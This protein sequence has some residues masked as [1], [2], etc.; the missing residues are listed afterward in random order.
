MLKPLGT[1]GVTLTVLLGACN[2]DQVVSDA[3]EQSTVALAQLWGVRPNKTA[4][5]E[6]RDIEAAVLIEAPETGVDLGWGWNT[7]RA[8]PIPTVCVEFARDSFDSQTTT[9]SFNEVNDSFELLET[10]DVSAEVS[11]KSIGYEAKGKADF[12]KQ[13]NISGF[14]STFV[15]EAEVQNGASFAAPTPPRELRLAAVGLQGEGAIRLTPEAVALARQGTERFKEVCGNGFVSATMGGARLTAVVNIQTSSRQERETVQAAVSGSGWGVKVEAAMKNDKSTAVGKLEREISF[16]QAGGREQEL[17]TDADKI[18]ARVQELAKQA[19]TAEKLFQIAVTPYEILENWP[20]GEELTGEE[21]E[22]NE[23]AS[24]WG[25]YNTLYDEIQAAM[26]TPGDFVVPVATCVSGEA[27]CTV[28]FK[29][30]ADATVLL[31]DLQD[32]VLAALDRLELDA[33]S[34]VVSEEDCAFNGETYRSP[35]AV[36]TR[37]P[38]PACFLVAGAGACKPAEA[39]PDAGSLAR[40][41][42]ANLRDMAKSR[43]RFGSLTPGCLS[44]ADIRAWSDRAGLQSMA[45][46]NTDVLNA[47]VAELNGREVPVLA[48]DPGA[49]AAATIWYGGDHAQTVATV[50]AQVRQAQATEAENKG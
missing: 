35:Y 8:E 44:N 2:P 40:F 27:G 11:V 29:K 7:F 45:L 32:E 41:V 25:A 28:S 43:C 49:Q 33:E 47:T 5:S 34:C 9:L 1:V 24:L 18:I 17:P 13:V 31:E 46:E 48:G 21:A 3:D 23:L 39:S 4:R 37:L 16:Y 42:D 19:S 14:S 26:D 15:I 22:F 50:L 20:R 30:V 38:V 12:A 10:M 6:Q 36:R